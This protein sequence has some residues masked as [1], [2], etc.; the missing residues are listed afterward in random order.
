[1]ESDTTK[2]M[3]ADMTVVELKSETPQPANMAYFVGSFFFPT[4]I[5]IFFF[6][7]NDHKFIVFSS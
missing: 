1:M 7:T 3:L 6:S 2:Y 5:F 4:S